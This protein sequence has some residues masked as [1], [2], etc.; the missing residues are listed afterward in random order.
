[1]AY[2]EGCAPSHPAIRR[3]CCSAC[4]LPNSRILASIDV[5]L[6]AD[7]APRRQPAENAGGGGDGAPI[8]QSRRRR[9]DEFGGGG[10]VA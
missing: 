3:R 10:G 4:T 6:T 7:A 8:R 9:C 5:Q 1:M 2:L